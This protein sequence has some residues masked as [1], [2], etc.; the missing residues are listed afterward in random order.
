MEAAPGKEI[1]S[2]LRNE[3]F[4]TQG[5]RV[6]CEQCDQEF[7]NVEPQEKTNQKRGRMQYM[8]MIA[9]SMNEGEGQML[10]L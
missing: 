8:E 6:K 7:V 5:K 9:L 4:P 2:C 3:T 1:G 10:R